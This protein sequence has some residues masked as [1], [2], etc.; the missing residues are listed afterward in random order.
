MAPSNHQLFLPTDALKNNNLICFFLFILDR[1]S[2]YDVHTASQIKM[3]PTSLK[4]HLKMCNA[5]SSIFVCKRTLSLYFH[6][7]L[8]LCPINEQRVSR[9]AVYSVPLL[10]Y[11]GFDFFYKAC[12]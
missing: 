3:S 6:L 5:N 9:H 12:M 8:Y 7:Q 4:V 11:D 1:N 10:L 2:S